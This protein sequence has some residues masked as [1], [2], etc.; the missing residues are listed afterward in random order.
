MNRQTTDEKEKEEE[1][2]EKERLERQKLLG[3]QGSIGLRQNFQYKTMRSKKLGGFQKPTLSTK[4]EEI[5][6][7]GQPFNMKKTMAGAKVGFEGGSTSNG[8]IL[9]AGS[10]S[11][12]TKWNMMKM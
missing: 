1:L 7:L 4:S 6:M 3:G 5:F 2:R 8:N 10:E 11:V 12:S 9:S